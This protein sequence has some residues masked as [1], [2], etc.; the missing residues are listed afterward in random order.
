MELKRSLWF[1]IWL[2]LGL[3]AHAASRPTISSFTPTSGAPGRSVTINGNNFLG[4]TQVTFN[5]VPATFTV[6]SAIAITTTV[7]LEATTGPITV[8]TSAGTAVSSAFFTVAPRIAEFDPTSGPPGTTVIINGFNFIT[9]GTVVRFNG[10]TAAASVVG[11]TQIHATVPAGANSGPI[12]VATGAGT[13][14]STNNF[15]ITGTEPVISD[16][17]PANGVPGT[18]VVI[19]GKFFTGATAVKFNGKSAD[20]T[21]VA[22]TQINATVP[23]GATT[24][25]ITITTASGTGTSATDFVVTA[26][27]IITGFTPFRGPAGTQVTIDGENFTG[28]TAVKFNNKAANYSIVAST[29]I[30]ATVPAGATSGPISVTTPGGTGSSSSNFVVSLAPVILDF[31]PKAGPVGTQVTIHG[32]NFQETTAVKFNGTNAASFS[33]VAP[34]QITAVVQPRASTGPITVATPAGTNTSSE[35]FQVTGSAPVITGFSPRGALPNAQVTIEGLNFSDATAVKFNGTNAT[36]FTVTADTQ[37][38]AVVPES[39]TTGPISVTTRFGTGSSANNFIAA[40]RI[41]S[42]SPIQGVLGASIVIKGTNFLE[43]TMVRIG[44]GA[45]EYTIDSNFQITAKVPAEA[46]TGNISVVNAAGIVGSTNEFHVLPKIVSFAPL[47]GPAGTPVTLKGGG[48]AGATNVFFGAVP[49]GF[50]VISPKEIQTV[51]PEGAVSGPIRVFTPEG[52]AV[53]ATSFIVSISADLRVSIT[54]D[55]EPVVAGT[56]LTYTIT[57]TNQGPNQVNNVVLT[58][59]LPSASIFVSAAVSQG[60]FTPSESQVVCRFGTIDTRRT[61]TATVVIRPLSS[62]TVTFKAAARGTEFDPD[63]ANNAATETTLVN[64]GAT[65]L[66][67]TRPAPS[68]VRIH[69]PKTATNFVLQTTDRLRANA[70]WSNVATPPTETSTEKFVTLPASDSVRFFRLIKP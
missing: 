39:A 28:A 68:S 43:S 17:T 29:Q 44:D 54:D 50:N 34:T 9:G 21:V 22:P 59:T 57:V 56:N 14:T 11:S 66:R 42:I 65:T 7:P 6:L 63:L 61:A 40:P 19:T 37:I 32:E 31:T 49:A 41:V 20:F 23:A 47:S 1:L 2:S 16:F 38:V 35:V 18:S 33:V 12:T 55:P 3:V 26:A 27:P 30:H 64:P 70:V 36:T 60:T 4:A 51:V 25:R 48:F 45:A 69:W 24:G 15:I 10:V 46:T 58:N 53:S 8:T 67:I 62:G 13:A 52:E 5:N